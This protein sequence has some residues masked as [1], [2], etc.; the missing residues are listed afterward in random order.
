MALGS[1]GAGLLGSSAS[2]ANTWPYPSTRGNSMA[3]TSRSGDSG[4]TWWACPDGGLSGR[5]FTS[6]VIFHFS[7]RRFLTTVT[8][9]GA[10]R[11]RR[12]SDLGARLGPVVEELFEADVGERVLHEL[13]EDGE[14][15]GGDVGAGLGGVDD[16]QRI[17]DGRREHLGLEAVVAV[18]LADV[19]DQVHAD[20]PDVVE[21]AEERADIGRASLG[22]E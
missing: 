18:D 7:A 20:G 4:R 17:A 11:E 14:G 16:V 5:A 2:P 8:P 1:R 12:E 3:R 15:H 13:F 19:A 10:W 9:R 6:S 21:A 22:G